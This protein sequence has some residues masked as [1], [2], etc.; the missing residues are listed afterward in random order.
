M[1]IG[2]L[3][4]GSL[5]L[6]NGII[7]CLYQFSFSWFRVVV[8]ILEPPWIRALKAEGDCNVVY[9]GISLGH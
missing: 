5:I 9:R 6:I 3:G 7:D 2:G 4:I 8:D 1:K